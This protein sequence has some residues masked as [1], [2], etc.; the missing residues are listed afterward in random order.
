MNQQFKCKK[1]PEKPPLTRAITDG[2]SNARV[3]CEELQQ[4]VLDDDSILYLISYRKASG[5]RMSATYISY[6]FSNFREAIVAFDAYLETLITTDN[7][8]QCYLRKRINP[9]KGV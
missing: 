1:T 9:K 6:V 5:T 2:I 3:I 4:A 7:I 8:H